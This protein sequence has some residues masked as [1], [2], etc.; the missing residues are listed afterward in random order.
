MWLAF[1]FAFR[2]KRQN[3]WRDCSILG[4]I[5]GIVN[6]CFDWYTFQN[7]PL[8]H[9]EYAIVANNLRLMG[10]AMLLDFVWGLFAVLGICWFG[11][12]C[13]WLFI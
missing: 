2:S 13:R 7:P 12:L 5:T 3:M 9:P 1:Y 11:W 6:A 4:I 10:T 8:Y